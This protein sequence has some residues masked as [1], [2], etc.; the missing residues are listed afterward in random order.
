M[1]KIL[2]LDDEY[3]ILKGVESML[4]H[5][6]VCPVKVMPY[7]DSVE[8]LD[9]LPTI[10]P[11]VVVLDINMPEL[12]GLEFIE[13]ALA[14][15]FIGSFII[16]SGYEDSN[17]LKRAFELHVADYI[18][19][20]INKEKLIASLC[21]I[22]EQQT[23]TTQS[24]IAT[25][26]FMLKLS[27]K[28]DTSSYD[29]ADWARLF[30]VGHYVLLCMRSL[31]P[32]SVDDTCHA[33]NVYFHP[34]Y[35]LQYNI[36]DVFLCAMPHALSSSEIFH[37]LSECGVSEINLPG[38]SRVINR[39]KLLDA[40]SNGD[41]L[42]FLP[43]ALSDS[44]LRELGMRDIIAEGEICFDIA[45]MI[46]NNVKVDD[47]IT[48]YH[49][50]FAQMGYS[51][52]TYLLGFLEGITALSIRHGYKIKPGQLQLLHRMIW[53]SSSNVAVLCANLADL[54]QQYLHTSKYCEKQEPRYSEKILCALIYIR[55]HFSEDIALNDVATAVGLSPSYFS[56]MFSR[57]VGTSFV[58]HLKFIRLEEACR[59]L[60]STS[61]LSVESIAASV[62][63][64]TV[65]QFYKVF[66]SV[67]NESPKSWKEHHSEHNLPSSMHY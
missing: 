43:E 33:L 57:E 64:Q 42:L 13:R 23:K 17:Y 24:M 10:Q 63:Y 25:L 62:G 6:Q 5:Q 16:I 55:S 26:R 44:I 46:I 53:E 50:L 4:L 29:L 45:R 7:I 34:I 38:I 21:H 3:I 49:A 12:N 8:A 36:A 60:R 14:L 31:E 66:K 27:G 65:G 37:I 18:I 20:P 58:N 1:L 56:S 28:R 67:Y 9:A 51:K 41:D 35:H 54:P 11:D 39:R 47:I 2:L 40:I 19:K 32:E 48:A 52:R 61:Q 30:P 59:L 22:H 15:G